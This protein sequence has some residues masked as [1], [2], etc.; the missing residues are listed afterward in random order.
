MRFN[1]ITPLLFATESAVRSAVKAPGRAARVRRRPAC[2]REWKRD[3]HLR[4]LDLQ[5]PDNLGQQSTDNGNV[6]N[7]NQYDATTGLNDGNEY[8][9]VFDNGNFESTGPA[10]LRRTTFNVDEQI[11]HTPKSILAKNFGLPEE[12]FASVPSPSPYITNGTADDDTRRNVAGG[13]GPL[14]GNASL[15]CHARVHLLED[16]P[17]GDG[18]LRVIDSTTFPAAKSI[19]AAVVALRPGGLREL[20]WHLNAEESLYF[21]RG[22]ARSTAFPGSSLARTFDFPAGDAAV[23]PDNRG[24]GEEDLVWVEIYKSDRVKDT[25]LTRWLALTPADIVADLLRIPVEVAENLKTEKRIL[26][27]GT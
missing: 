23:F 24:G 3:S 8:L 27:K 14:T 17:R 18:T 2:R 15:V 9:L 5:N 12:V 13:N 1:Q 6:P 10:Y 16:A 22:K 20:R 26:V 21:H 19:A 7:L 4:A 25:P 11:T